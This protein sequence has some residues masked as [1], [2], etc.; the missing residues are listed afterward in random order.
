LLKSQEDEEEDCISDEG[1]EGF[2]EEEEGSSTKL[3]NFIPTKERKFSD[4]ASMRDKLRENPGAYHVN[5]IIP[6]SPVR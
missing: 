2:D 4:F 5:E 3:I 6:L 1:D